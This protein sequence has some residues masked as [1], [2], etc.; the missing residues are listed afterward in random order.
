[1]LNAIRKPLRVILEYNEA[2]FDKPF[3]AP[4]NPIRQV[5]S[6]AFFFYWVAIVSG[7]YVYILFDTAVSHAYQ[8]VEYMTHEQWYLGGVMRSLHRYSSDGMVLAAVLHMAREFVMDRYRGVRWFAWFTGVPILW[9]LYTSGISGY[10]LVWDELGQYVA[11]GSMEWLDWLNVFGNK[12]ANNFLTPEAMNDRFFSL[13]VFIHIFVPIFLLFMMWIHVIRVQEAKINP[14]RGLMIGTLVMLTVLSLVWPAVSHGPANLATYPTELNLDW[15]FLVVYPVFE[16]VGAGNM[17]LICFLVTLLLCVLPWLPPL[18]KQTQA[19]VNLERC[20][21]CTQCYEDCPYGAITMQPRSDG[22][23]FELEAVVN[24]KNCVRCGICAG[25]CPMAT[26]FRAKNDFSTG[27]DLPDFS[28][29]DVRI[30]MSDAME[31][32]NAEKGDGVSTLVFGCKRSVDASYLD[33]PGSVAINLNCIGQLPPSFVDFALSKKGV[34][35]VLLTGC[36]GCFNR[37]GIRWTQDR[38]MGAR[39]P[40]LRA[41][42]PRDRIHTFWASHID[43]KLLSDELESFRER[44]NNPPAAEDVTPAV[45]EKGEG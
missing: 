39:D 10:W 22:R 1:M 24:P 44:L 18:K 4:W 13:L 37:F 35:G 45:S 11:I 20:N 19:T 6:L 26:P 21:G 12:I 27:I 29:K 38:L 33:Q 34:D 3:G 2:I 15:F 31:K 16:S 43:K 40:Y 28:L 30:A 25:A 8:S 23:P 36:R 14:P 17:W 7:I 5:G 32:A 9:L 42:V 41:R